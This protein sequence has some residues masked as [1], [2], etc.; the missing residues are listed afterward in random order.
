MRPITVINGI[1]LGSCLAIFLGLGVTLFI[2]LLLAPENPSLQREL[3]PLGV[4]TGIF[5]GMTGTAA[6][7]FYGQLKRLAWRWLAEAVL[8]AAGT[9]TVLY[10]LPD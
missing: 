4:Y 7:A 3:A 8:L 10:L 1:I 5:G 6:L 2:F 9:A